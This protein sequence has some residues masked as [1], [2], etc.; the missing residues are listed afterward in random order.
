M[1]IDNYPKVNFAPTGK[2]HLYSVS[3]SAEGYV[4]LQDHDLS[5]NIRY[6]CSH[7]GANY[8]SWRNDRGDIRLR[9][10]GSAGNG[11]MHISK[12]LYVDGAVFLIE[13]SIS[14]QV[15]GSVAIRAN[16]KRAQY[17]NMIYG[18]GEFN[19]FYIEV[20]T[21]GVVRYLNCLSLKS[22]GTISLAWITPVYGFDVYYL[23]YVDDRI[24]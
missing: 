3:M 5:H 22:N 18:N 24:G 6:Y 10:H 14:G 17:Y 2:K 7:D 12:D 13:I 4:S 8:S 16:T 1:L 19:S 11:P 20:S 21:S 23:G 9:L 15:R